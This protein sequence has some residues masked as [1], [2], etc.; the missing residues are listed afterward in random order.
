MVT[1]RENLGCLQNKQFLKMFD[2]TKFSI[3][4]LVNLWNFNFMSNKF[5]KFL[6]NNWLIR[7]KIKFY[8]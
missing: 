6:K 8:I 3:L 4:Y 7:Y 5:L 1:L 2:M